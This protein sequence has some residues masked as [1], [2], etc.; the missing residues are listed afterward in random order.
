M[1]RKRNSGLG[2]NQS[3]MTWTGAQAI[4]RPPE[5]EEQDRPESRYALSRAPSQQSLRSQSPVRSTYGSRP[6]TPPPQE[7]ATRARSNSGFFE[8]P[9]SLTL[10]R[11]KFL[12]T[13]SPPFFSHRTFTRRTMMM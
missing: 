11:F 2:W 3:P 6:S 1:P 9:E 4:P 10:V 7:I 5:P 12:P 13:S 8:P